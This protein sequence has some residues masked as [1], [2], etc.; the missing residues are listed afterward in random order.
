MNADTGRVL[1]IPRY[2]QWA[3]GRAAWT[4]EDSNSALDHARGAERDRPSAG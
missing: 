2:L 3:L 1:G 4:N